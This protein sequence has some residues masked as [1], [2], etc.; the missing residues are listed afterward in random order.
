MYKIIKYIYIKFIFYPSRTDY[1]QHP[2]GWSVP[3]DRLKSRANG[4]KVNAIKD[5][6]LKS[7]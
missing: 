3:A 5:I 7:A 6:R 2:P 4:L 1:A